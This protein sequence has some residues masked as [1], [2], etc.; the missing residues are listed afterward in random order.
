[1]RALTMTRWAAR[2]PNM[3]IMGAISGMADGAELVRH[4]EFKEALARLGKWPLGA[5]WSDKPA[6]AGVLS[7]GE[8]QDMSEDCLR[9]GDAWW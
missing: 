9:Q 3:A 6:G 8:H 1:M 2:L 7:E 5:A 4:Q